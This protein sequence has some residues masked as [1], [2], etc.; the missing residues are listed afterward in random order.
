MNHYKTNFNIIYTKTFTL[1]ELEKMVPWE[2]EIYA[3]LLINQFEKEKEEM[4]EL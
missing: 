1:T 2:R 3:N 4:K